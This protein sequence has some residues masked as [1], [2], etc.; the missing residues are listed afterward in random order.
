[1]SLHS[2]LLRN[3]SQIRYRDTKKLQEYIETSIILAIKNHPL[4]EK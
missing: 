2:M 1:L 3:F 4:G